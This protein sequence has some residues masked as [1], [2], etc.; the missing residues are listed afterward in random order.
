EQAGVHEV[1]LTED[2]LERGI[3]AVAGGVAGATSRVTIGLGVVNPFSRHPAVTAMETGALDEIS[4]GRTIL[5]LGGSNERW[6]SEWL[7]IDFAKPLGAVR[8]A[9]QIIGDLLTTGSVDV[10]GPRFQVHAHMSVHPSHHVPIW[11]GVKGLRGLEAARDDADGVILSVLS[12]PAYVD[13]VRGIVGSD[14]PLGAFVEVATNDDGAAARDSVREFVAR[15][16]GMHG[17]QPITRV[18]GLD[19][20]TVDR[21]R[22]ALL[23]GSPDADA[24]TDEMIDS[25]VVAGTLADCAAGLNRFAA[26]GLDTLIVGDRPESSVDTVVATATACW[27]TAGFEL[28]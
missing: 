19:A 1:W 17:D 2:Y 21:L 12:S 11:F 15:F 20:E 28:A 5:A 18:A 3:F 24:V 25:F 10:D 8:E 7:G 23:A 27:A 9:R 6:M 16:L 14:L 22:D 26:A 4:G 13:W